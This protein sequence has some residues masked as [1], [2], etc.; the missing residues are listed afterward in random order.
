MLIRATVAACA[1]VL[2]VAAPASA[3]ASATATDSIRDGQQWVL[4][5]LDVPQA[6]Q[7][8]TGDNVT[9][10]VIDS[11]VNGNVSDLAG[12][13][14]TGPDLT[15]LSTPGTSPGW[16]VHGTWMASIIA[17]HGHD[18][19]G[20][21]IIGVAP[22]SRILSIR[23][24]PDHSDPGYETYDRE[25]ESRIQSSL[26]TGI[27]DAVNDGAKVISMSIGYSVPSAAVRSALEY[28]NAKGA[29]VVASSGNSG[30]D[31]ESRDDGF[32]PVSFPADYPGVIGVG[33]V[34][35][36]GEVANFSSDNL[37]VLVSAPGVNVP[38]Q[39]RDGQYWLVSGT[40]P[41]CALVAGVAALI[42]SRYPSLAPN[43]V[44]EALSYDTSDQP[45]GGYDVKVGFGT[46]NAAAA[47]AEA[48]RLST[49]RAGAT[50]EETS[51]HF[52]G[53]ASAVAAAPVR[54][55]GVLDLVLFAV[56]AL[57]FLVL[58]VAAVRRIAVIRGIRLAVY[59]TV[60]SGAHAWPAPS[61]D[62]SPSDGGTSSGGGGQPPLSAPPPNEPG[63]HH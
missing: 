43:L 8:S 37:S 5:M 28:A 21:G 41:A 47:L 6:W 1:A 22:D 34:T 9:V 51:A 3:P 15:G 32:A 19:G 7:Q 2:L 39:G 44:A 12:S 20:S 11:G 58:T 36:T 61:G 35:S 60:A 62:S 13:V 52:G 55:R 27:R 40:S 4:D 23:V 16:G 24:I 46:V 50:G 53:G 59:G 45:A 38:A 63:Y 26:A 48:G 31:D 25:P 14:T 30:T 54:S 18:G 56:L 49:A 10:A 17:G 42:K 33:A 57:V 29:V